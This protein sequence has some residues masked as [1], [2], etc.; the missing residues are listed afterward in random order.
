MIAWFYQEDDVEKNPEW[1]KSQKE[2]IVPNV[3]SFRI[4]VPPGDSVYKFLDV[5]VEEL[6]VLVG[7]AVVKCGTDGVADFFWRGD[8]DLE[9]LMF[10]RT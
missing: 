3:R 7:T 4:W 8:C 6:F 9:F 2:D 10:A 1:K 5:F